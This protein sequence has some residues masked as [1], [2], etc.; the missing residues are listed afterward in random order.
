MIDTLTYGPTQLASEEK[1]ITP[2]RF[3]GDER[4]KTMADG[5]GASDRSSHNHQPLMP[6]SP[7]KEHRLT[8]VKREAN[9]QQEALPAEEIS[10]LQPKAVTADED[11]PSVEPPMKKLAVVGDEIASKLSASSSSSAS[12]TSGDDEDDTEQVPVDAQERTSKDYYFDSYAHHAIHEE[13]LKDEVRTR[14]YQMAIM[15]NKHLF[16]DKVRLCCYRL[17][18][19]SESIRRLNFALDCVGCGL[20]NGNSVHVCGPSRCQA[21]LCCR[22]FLHY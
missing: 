14:T 12:V 16:Q 15:Q 11:S 20:R 22:L 7:P 13:M 6:E 3:G 17:P 8:P 9:A 19:A 4:Q 5:R 18:N 2:A 10:L 1:F 21:C